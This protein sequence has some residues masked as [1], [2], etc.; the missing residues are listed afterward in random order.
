MIFSDAALRAMATARPDTDAAFL[1]IKGVGA[2]KL[3]RLSPAFMAALRPSGNVADGSA[4]ETLRLFRAGCTMTEIAEMRSLTPEI[5]GAHIAEAIENGE[6]VEIDDLVPPHRQEAI[7]EAATT[8][9]TT[10]LRRLKAVLG[11]RF[12][13]TDI[14]LTCAVDR[15]HAGK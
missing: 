15:Q 1:S 5:C 10:D 8:E 9:G 12:T 6:L 3:K 4:A 11:E 7:R 13:Y 2:A 14:R